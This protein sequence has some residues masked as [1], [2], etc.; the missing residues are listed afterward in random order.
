[1]KL[2]KYFLALYFFCNVASAD[3][4]QMLSLQGTTGQNDLKQSTSVLANFGLGYETDSGIYLDWTL[5]VNSEVFGE[6]L[7]D[8]HFTD[9]NQQSGQ[10]DIVAGYNFKVTKRT[11]L[12]LG[13]GFETSIFSHNC[14][15]RLIKNKYE[16]ICDKKH[17]AGPTYKAGFFFRTSGKSIVGLE[18]NRDEL[19]ATR[20]YNGLS[21]VIKSNF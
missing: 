13:L 17:E 5:G 12:K 6:V 11:Y 8:R 7:L 20:K 18:F 9:D 21:I 2:I 19:S 14:S 16:Y 10:M 3:P 15:N 4:Y 1:M